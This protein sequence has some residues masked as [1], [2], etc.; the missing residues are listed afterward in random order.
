MA[1]LFAGFGVHQAGTTGA[2]KARVR[3]KGTGDTLR[4]SLA[5][6][7]G[8][9]A[10][11]LPRGTFWTQYIQ[12]SEFDVGVFV[13]KL[14][15]DK[16]KKPVQI[17]CGLLGFT[18]RDGVAAADPI[19]IDTDKNVMTAKGGFSFKDESLDMRFRADSKKFSLF[20]GQSPVGIKGYFAQ[21]GINIISP[22][23]LARGGAGLALGAV[24]SPLAAVLAFV[25]VGDAKAAACGP[26]LAGAQA[27]AMRTTKGKPRKD[28]GSARENRR[29]AGDRK[30]PDK[31]GM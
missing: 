15:Q 28:V 30:Q 16:L 12:L 22:Q 10:I 9:I 11:I 18:V 4:D 31:L 29:Q 7:N 19:L 1:K 14:L 24:A 6:S 2:I 25:D 27:S 5:T 26:V 23:L 20:S 17:N 8:R 3:M 13:Q 21:P